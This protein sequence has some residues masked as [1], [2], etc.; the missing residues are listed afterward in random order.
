MKTQLG[1]AM[2]I[3]ARRSFKERKLPNR[4]ACIRRKLRA[5]AD[6]FPRGSMLAL[7]WCVFQLL[8]GPAVHAQAENKT[9]PV[10]ASEPQFSGLNTWGVFGEYSPTSSHIFL[11]VSEER[12]IVILGGEY[13]RRLHLNRWMGLY[14]VAQVRPLVLEGDPAVVGYQDVS[15]HQVVVR[16]PVA[17]R[18]DVVDRTSV[19]PLPGNVQARFFYERQWTYSAGV[20]PLGIKLNL[21]PRHRL[22][23]VILGAA[24]CLVSTR[25]MPVDHASTFNFS[26]EFGAGFEWF[27]RPARSMRIDYRIH[28]ISSA[29]IGTKNP[30]VDS[31][32]FQVTYSFGR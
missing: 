8:H 12:R 30:G 21:G 10:S 25:D 6:S 28:H 23:P 22:Q 1:C 14:Y 9:A 31:G 2:G 16:L 17:K 29:Y 19:F 11:G 20:N 7:V 27:Y 24:G 15:S 18:V 13:A 5:L 32:I 26:F 4:R 3:V